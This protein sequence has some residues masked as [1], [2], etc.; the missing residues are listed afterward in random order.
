MIMSPGLPVL[1]PGHGERGTCG[2]PMIGMLMLQK[3]GEHQVRLVVYPIIYRISCIPGGCSG[4]FSING[5]SDGIFLDENFF[6]AK[7]STQSTN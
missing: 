2:T 6:G 5:R 4:F 7:P 3:S 1:L